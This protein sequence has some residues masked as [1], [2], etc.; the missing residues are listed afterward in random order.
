MPVELLAAV[1]MLLYGIGWAVAAW[2]VVE[3]RPALLHWMAYALLQ[4][5]SAFIAAPVMAS[6]GTPPVASLLS[7]TLGFAA[8]VRGVDLF[9]SG[10]PRLDAW[11]AAVLL[12]TLAAVIAVAL[13][14]D[15]PGAR[16]RWM[17]EPYSLGLAVL[18][19]SY[20][21][22]NWKP[23]R[24]AYGRI[25]V[26]VVLA[27]M[28]LTGL[29]A[30]SSALARLRL[31]DA[32][33]A[34]LQSA[35]RLPNV[36]SSLVVSGLFNF[37]Y[38]FLL[39]ARLLGRL[40]ETAR[41]DHV[42]GVLNRRSIEQSLQAAWE[43]HRRTGC[44]VAVALVDI[45]RF[46]AI[47]DRHG[48]AI[49]DRTLAWAAGTLRESTRPYDSVGRWGGEE[50]VIVMVGARAEHAEANCERLRATLSSQSEAGCG[51][52]FTASL[53]VA[54]ARSDDSTAMALVDR[55]DQA[56]YHAKTEGRDRV[57]VAL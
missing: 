20:A 13:A 11:G 34:Q 10:R 45:D 3:E 29:V 25:T 9:V 24:G 16:R 43:Q 57:C 18:L 42:T 37:G 21:T 48:H 55:A 6:G 5:A 44:G 31:D 33:L 1:Q 4:S 28:A 56:M 8:A 53:G 7:S 36:M 2:L 39:V 49:G 32:S 46:K 52:A 54:V 40:R 51:V 30:I 26:A 19:L 27:P 41:T 15:D 47:N 14:I 35:A 50:F 23:L 17:G 38:I 12:P 22:L